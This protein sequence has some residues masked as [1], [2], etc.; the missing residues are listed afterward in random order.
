MLYE[1]G[2]KWHGSPL[3]PSAFGTMVMVFKQRMQCS[4]LWTCFLPE[5]NISL[6]AFQIFCLFFMIECDVQPRMLL[7]EFYEWIWNF[8]CRIWSSF[9][10]WSL[11]PNKCTQ[12]SSSCAKKAAIIRWKGNSTKC[13]LTK[14]KATVTDMH[15][16]EISKLSV[17]YQGVWNTLHMGKLIN[18][19]SI[20][21]E[22]SFNLKYACCYYQVFQKV[23][24]HYTMGFK[25]S[26]LGLIKHILSFR[27]GSQC[28]SAKAPPVA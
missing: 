4:N 10:A 17:I 18:L 21:L 9:S 27:L 26:H 20:S 19:T 5:S 8:K 22:K 2:I 14:K 3:T 7:Y 28:A 23:N 11:P 13:G 25:T 15:A 24:S 1:F 12:I 6:K 16:L